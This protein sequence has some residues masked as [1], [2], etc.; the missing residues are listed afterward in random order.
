MLKEFKAHTDGIYY[1]AVSPDGKTFL[2][3]ANDKTA[4]LWDIKGTVIKK[5]MGHTEEINS[6]AFSPDGRTI[7]TGSSDMT[8][9]LW[10]VPVPMKAFV[11]SDRIEPLSPEQK[12]QFGIK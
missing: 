11:A 2:T 1:M 5:F 4:I 8:A 3:G 10:E 7:M 6:V 9:R 12:K